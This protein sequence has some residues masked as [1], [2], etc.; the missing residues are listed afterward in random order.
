ML[1]EQVEQIF[2]LDDKK[3]GGMWRTVQKVNH[4]SIYVI[5][6]VLEDVDELIDDVNQ[7]YDG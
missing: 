2:Y 6:E 3:N 1:P 4:R 7:I 5:S